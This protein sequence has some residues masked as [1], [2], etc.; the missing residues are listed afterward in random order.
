MP[1]VKLV[2]TDAGIAEVINAEA[3]G[4][5]PVKLTE[6]GL[7]TGKYTA[8]G[9]QEA[10]VSEFKRLDTVAGG[11]VGTNIIHVTVTD[12]S[13]ASYAVYEIGLYTESGTL[14]AVYSQSLPIIQKA[15][16]A[17]MMLSL[18]I[19]LTNLSNTSVTFGDT[20]FTMAPATTDNQGI[21]ELATHEEVQAGTDDTR[22]VTP[23]GLKSAMDGRTAS[24][25][26]TGLVELATAAEVQAGTDGGKA[27]TP[28]GLSSRTAT[29]GRTGLAEIA[30]QTE[31][32]AGT[33]DS[34][35][36][37]PKKLKAAMD[38]WD[39]YQ[40]I[41]AFRKSMIGALFP[42][43]RATLPGYYAKPDGSLILF[44]D[45]PE[46]A[47]AYEDGAFDGMLLEA[48]ATDEEKQTWAGKWV[49]NSQGTG[50][51]APRLQ[52][53]FLRNAGEQDSLGAYQQDAV[54]AGIKNIGTRPVP[55][56]NTPTVWITGDVEQKEQDSP[57]TLY[58]Q[59]TTV[60]SNQIVVYT[61]NQR[62][63]DETRPCNGSLIYGIYLGVSA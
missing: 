57:D 23:A 54:Q 33:D 24:D 25:S 32:D 29:E 51:Y 45:Y 13:D 8:T 43:A 26:Q 14:F 37:T 2:V 44:E 28:A 10:L 21:A 1:S 40:Q 55:N 6:I 31:V 39:F 30:T 47:E 48:T 38:G 42:F 11:A 35:I 53:L 58:T 12:D 18:D 19:A 63:S 41:E 5:A 56:N 61:S 52:G 60:K 49:K 16:A 9:G 20:D 50:L 27:V 62:N 15:S 22:I 46:F 4:T 17:L 3:D 36:V 7:G 59:L 34:R